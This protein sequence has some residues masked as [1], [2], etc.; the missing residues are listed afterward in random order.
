[1]MFFR[2]VSIFLWNSRISHLEVD[3]WGH[4]GDFQVYLGTL[5]AR[6]GLGGGASI[7]HLSPF[8]SNLL[9]GLLS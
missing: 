9:A 6:L 3:M 7:R 4:T 5:T 1:M 2:E 8:C